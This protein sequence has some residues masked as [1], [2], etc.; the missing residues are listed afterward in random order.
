MSN[1]IPTDV[2]GNT[3]SN[4]DFSDYIDS[5]D[6][7]YVNEKDDTIE[8]LK[9]V[10]EPK[11]D[12]DVVN[13]IYLNTKFKVISNTVSDLDQSL[14]KFTS[15]EITTVNNK[16][17]LLEKNIKDELQ[18]VNLKVQNIYIHELEKNKCKEYRDILNKFKPVFWI[19]AMLPYG[20][21]YSPKE[22]WM[23]QDLTGST[24]DI[25][26]H[27][28]LKSDKNHNTGIY[29]DGESRIISK[30]EFKDIFSLFILCRK[31]TKKSGRLIT[32]KWGNNVVGFWHDAVDFV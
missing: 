18:K 2:F 17:K 23:F 22:F 6:T 24:T 21:E 12:L 27:P 20:F 9:V 15:D 29:F 14:R 10:K 25:I 8:N 19:S 3:L 7:K 32:G 4:V 13:K 30:Y 1:Y 26:G 11:D 31:N 16:N 28:Y 5:L